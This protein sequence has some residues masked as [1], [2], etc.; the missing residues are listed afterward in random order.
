MI[1]FTYSEKFF[2]VRS[3]SPGGVG[4]AAQLMHPPSSCLPKSLARCFLTSFLPHK[5]CRGGCCRLLA[6]VHEGSWCSFDGGRVTLFWD[7]PAQTLSIQML[8]PPP[9]VAG[10][11]NRVSCKGWLTFRLPSMRRWGGWALGG[12]LYAMF[13]VGSLSSSLLVRCLTS[14]E[15]GI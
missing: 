5:P 7:R 10:L 13:L 3:R 4:E 2:K 9:V 15:T 14:M 12:C 11:V 1:A 8:L 6:G